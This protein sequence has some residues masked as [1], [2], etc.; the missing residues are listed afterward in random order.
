MHYSQ[1]GFNVKFTFPGFLNV[2]KATAGCIWNNPVMSGWDL[3]LSHSDLECGLFAEKVKQLVC[4]ATIWTINKKH[5]FSKYIFF[6]N[7]L[8]FLFIFSSNYFSFNFYIQHYLRALHYV[9]KCVFQKIKAHDIFSQLQRIDGFIC[10]VFI[11]I[12]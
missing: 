11:L 3:Y 12:F 8:G 2:K 10:S 4:T 1:L 9:L 6:H 5:L 7:N